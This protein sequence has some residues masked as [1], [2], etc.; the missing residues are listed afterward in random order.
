M[1]LFP[2]IV[3]SLKILNP[4]IHGKDNTRIRMQ[5]MMQAFFL[6]ILNESMQLE[7]MFSKTAITVEK[8]AKVMKRKKRLPHKMPPFMFTKTLGKVIKIRL[9]PEFTSMPKEKQAGKIMIPDIIATK[10]SRKQILKPSLVRV[11]SFDM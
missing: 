7:R 2:M 11:E 8:L 5:F 6:D 3:K 1:P 4:S 9:G 10:V